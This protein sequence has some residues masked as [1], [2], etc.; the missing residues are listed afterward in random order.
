MM[1]AAVAGGGHAPYVLL[2]AGFVT[3]L[4]QGLDP[5]VPGSPGPTSSTCGGG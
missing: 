5:M 1:R 4:P 2:K 3:P